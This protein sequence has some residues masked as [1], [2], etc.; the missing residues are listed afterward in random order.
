[1][2]TFDGTKISFGGNK[3]QMTHAGSID[4]S[5]TSNEEELQILRD[6]LISQV[7]EENAETI[8]NSWVTA[9][10]NY[11]DFVIDRKIDDG[12]GPSM[13]SL[14]AVNEQI[15][16]FLTAR[17]LKRLSEK[18]NVKTMKIRVIVDDEYSE[19]QNRNKAVTI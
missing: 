15:L 18:S 8:W 17:V 3:K 19:G 1:M 4:A 7:G 5:N 14:I 16:A 13:A 12:S 10:E 2:K 6:K 11:F 9:H